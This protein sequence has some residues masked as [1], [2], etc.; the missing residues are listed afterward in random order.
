MQ[1]NHFAYVIVND[2][3]NHYFVEIGIMHSYTVE[4]FLKFD[5]KIY[6]C[7]KYKAMLNNQ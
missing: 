5:T 4:C 3:Y 1:S 7:F 6:L 2:L